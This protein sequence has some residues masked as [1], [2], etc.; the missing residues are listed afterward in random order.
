M[1]KELKK[2]RKEQK[3]IYKKV[4]RKSHGLWKFLTL[5]SAPLAIVLLIA[6]VFISIFDNTMAL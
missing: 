3:K 2:Q 6:T 1:D 5:L 4:R